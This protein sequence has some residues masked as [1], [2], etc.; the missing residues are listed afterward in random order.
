MDS[1]QIAAKIEQLHP[2]P[3][4]YIDTTLQNEAEQLVYGFCFPL[5]AL[6]MPRTAQ[7]IVVP[8]ALPAFTA[9]R[10][11]MFGGSFEDMAKTP[12]EVAWASAKPGLEKLVE[13]L[14]EKK[15]DEGPF[16]RG[17]QISFADFIVVAVIKS[18]KRSGEDFY[19]GIVGFNPAIKKL[20]DAVAPHL[21]RED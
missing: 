21:V 17:S 16:I 4:L 11:R 7:D 20:Y 18:F 13:F 3:P 2:S 10:E 9:P 8:S 12:K 5:F 14:K 15:I 19:E 1:A 6:Y